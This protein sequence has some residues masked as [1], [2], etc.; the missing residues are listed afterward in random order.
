MNKKIIAVTS[1][2]LVIGLSLGIFISLAFNLH[3][4]LF[5]SQTE[6]QKIFCNADESKSSGW[7]RSYPEN[8]SRL[9]PVVSAMNETEVPSIEITVNIYNNNSISLFNV[10]MEVTYRTIE[11]T[12]STITKTNLGFVDA[13]SEKHVEVTITNPY[14]SLWDTKK[15]VYNDPD[16][17]WVNGTVCTLNL[18]DINTVAYG[19]AQP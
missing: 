12:W 6:Q 2:G 15:A 7:F 14:V 10:G 16:T 17:H 18:D 4:I 1:I 8:R 13:L 11:N 9:D 19:Y 5:P 3:N